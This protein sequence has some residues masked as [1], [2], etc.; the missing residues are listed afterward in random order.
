[1]CSTRCC[2]YWKPSSCRFLI[3]LSGS[4][5]FI[6]W[7]LSNRPQK[8][9]CSSL[10][11][12]LIRRKLWPVP[13]KPS[14]CLWGPWNDLPGSFKLE[15]AGGVRQGGS[16]WG[17]SGTYL[18]PYLPSSLVDCSK[19]AG[20]PFCS[21]LWGLHQLRVTFGGHL[22]CTD[23]SYT[24]ASQ[25]LRMQRAENHSSH[26]KYV[27]GYIVRWHGTYWTG[28]GSS[29]FLGPSAIPGITGSFLSPLGLCNCLV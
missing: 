14:H 12:C 2:Y 25:A 29:T 10:P 28:T 26:L 24:A 20:Y 21:W 16:R 19:N 22:I 27:T 7:L 5:R 3:N 4:L 15:L 13:W 8:W 6:T 1:M 9:L 11:W 17:Q 23:L 18:T